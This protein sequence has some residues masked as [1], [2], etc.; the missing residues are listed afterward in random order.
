M[1]EDNNTIM[2]EPAHLKE[3]LVPVDFSDRSLRALEFAKGMAQKFDARLTLLNVVDLN[4][5]G[6][7]V[8][9]IDLAMLEKDLMEGSK[10]R[11]EALVEDRLNG[12]SVSEP[13]QRIGPPALEIV[14][15]AKELGSDLIVIST[16][17]YTG[18][19]HV[20]LGSV[21]EQINRHAPCPTLIVPEPHEK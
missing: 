20:L 1:S 19:K 8:G 6:W 7:E 21:A 13:L 18:L 12:V 16:H 9:A 17:G 3:I 4:P 10:R 2:V 5:M 15:A 14:E 11:L